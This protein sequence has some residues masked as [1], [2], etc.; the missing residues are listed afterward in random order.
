M[1][2]QIVQVLT[3]LLKTERPIIP[4]E[5]DIKLKILIKNV[6]I[7]ILRKGIVFLNFD[8]RFNFLKKRPSIVQLMCKT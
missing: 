5:C 7:K 8:L 2:M 6:G 4:S 1:N 3:A